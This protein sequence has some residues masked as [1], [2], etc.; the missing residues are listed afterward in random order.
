MRVEDLEQLLRQ[1]RANHPG[2][3]LARLE[4]NAAAFMRGESRLSSDPLQRPTYWYKG[5]TD[6]PWHDP[7]NYP[8]IPILEANYGVIREDLE[9]LLQDRQRLQAFRGGDPDTMADY[10]RGDLSIF[11]FRDQFASEAEQARM[12]HNCQVAS[13]TAA[14]IQSLPRLGETT[15]FSIIGPSTHLR[16]HYGAE[17]LRVFVHLGMII[18]DGC[19]IKVADREVV[20]EE[21]KCIVFDDSYL[22]EA[23]N[24]GKHVRTIL[25]VELWHHEL[26]AGEIEFFKRLSVMRRASQAA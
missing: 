13:R 25:L 16:P 4:E 11:Y 5:L 21:G 17:N 19:A 3:D 20:W 26:N 14:V 22:H 24:R 8:A 23:W 2:I 6:Q 18:P 10:I 9:R 12:Q 15:F 7:R 1:V